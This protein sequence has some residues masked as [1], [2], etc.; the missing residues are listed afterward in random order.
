MEREAE[1]RGRDEHGVR[2][3]T[4]ER[5]SGGQCRKSWSRGSL[6]AAML[7]RKKRHNAAHGRGPG[8]DCVVFDCCIL[9][10]HLLAS[11]ISSKYHPHL[12]SNKSRPSPMVPPS[13][14]ETQDTRK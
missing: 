6:L 9:N 10:A 12:I 5:Q 1:G 11:K 2:A 4:A 14:R 7:W 13:L 8:V 3:Q